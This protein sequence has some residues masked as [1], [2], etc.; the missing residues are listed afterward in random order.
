M[1]WYSK[2]E[3]C[4]KWGNET[5]TCFTISNGV[6]QGGILSPTLFSIYIDDLSFIL[7]EIG[8]G[9]HI[10]ELCINHVSYVDDLCLTAYC[11]LALQE[12]IGLCYKYSLKI[13]LNF[14]ATRSYCVA[15]TPK[16]YKLTLPSLPINHM[17]ISYTDS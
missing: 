8:I 13:D 1:F 7:P 2:Q 11:A 15:F 5:S 12:Q 6:R 9:C 4:I 17:P 14:N 10:D 16:L 3:I